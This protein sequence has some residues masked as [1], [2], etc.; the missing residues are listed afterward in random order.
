MFAKLTLTG[1]TNAIPPR[2]MYDL[3][4]VQTALDISR[5]FETVG[6]GKDAKKV[7]LSRIP[8]A[9]RF[10]FGWLEFVEERVDRNIYVQGAQTD[11]IDAPNLV[12]RRSYGSKQFKRADVLKIDVRKKIA[13]AAT[14]ARQEGLS[15]DGG[16][17][18]TQDAEMALYG[19]FIAS[20]DTLPAIYDEDGVMKKL[21]PATWGNFASALLTRMAAIEA[22]KSAHNSALLLLND[23]AAIVGYDFTTGW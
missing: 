18:P 16:V 19:L 5:I 2:P 12:I 7:R 14:A 8:P 20:G 11:V 15:F 13:G 23:P 22:N 3:P 17:Y 10:S 4:I 21:N 1:M 6:R 9:E